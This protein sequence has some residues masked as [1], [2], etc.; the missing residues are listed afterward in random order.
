[1]SGERKISAAAALGV[2]ELPRTGI[3]A[4][5]CG[6]PWFGALS[7]GITTDRVTGAA[8]ALKQAPNTVV[9]GLKVS[10]LTALLVPHTRLQRQHEHV[11]PFLQA[12]VFDVA[13]LPVVPEHQDLAGAAAD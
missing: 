12:G 10:A 9:L 6:S 3:A 8:E 2:S 11:Q 4:A 7:P 13:P 5:G 1:M